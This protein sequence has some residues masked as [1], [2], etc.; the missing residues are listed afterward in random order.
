[1]PWHATVPEAYDL[2]TSTLCPDCSRAYISGTLLQLGLA[3][4]STAAVDE[5]SGQ[6]LFAH[7]SDV[8]FDP[9]WESAVVNLLT[10][11]YAVEKTRVLS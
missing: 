3:T 1:M 9:V 7:A 10:N 4:L 2:T 11:I 6:E 8:L 5:N